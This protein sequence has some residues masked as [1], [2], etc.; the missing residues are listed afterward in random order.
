[1]KN[2]RNDYFKGGDVTVRKVQTD[3]DLKKKIFLPRGFQ[4]YFQSIFAVKKNWQIK[5]AINVHKI[6]NT[7]C[8]LYKTS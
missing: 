3:C 8:A 1:M 7:L 5:C 4:K 2:I 6:K